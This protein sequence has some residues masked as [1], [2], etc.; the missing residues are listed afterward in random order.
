V[1]ASGL[2]TNRPEWSD[3]LLFLSPAMSSVETTHQQSK[4][5]KS[6][7]F[8]FDTKR[9][10]PRQRLP[11]RHPGCDLFRGRIHSTFAFHFS[12]RLPVTVFFVTVF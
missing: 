3:P 6:S 7:D 8:Y 12:L 2:P 11:I 10:P 5:L 9:T 1:I 4:D